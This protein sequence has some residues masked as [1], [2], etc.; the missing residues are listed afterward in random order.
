VNLGLRDW[1]RSYDGEY[2]VCVYGASL[3]AFNLHLFMMW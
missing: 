3:S 1:I 2:G